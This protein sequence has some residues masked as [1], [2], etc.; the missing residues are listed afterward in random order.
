MAPTSPVRPATPFAAALVIGL[1]AGAY[2]GLTT[3]KLGHPGAY[4]DELNKAVPAFA[5][6]GRPS[7]MSRTPR[8][9]PSRSW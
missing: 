7:H 5:W 2:F 3:P 8:S 9:A 6:V 4:Y 1:A